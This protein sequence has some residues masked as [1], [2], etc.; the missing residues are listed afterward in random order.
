[1]RNLILSVLFLNLFVGEIIPLYGAEKVQDTPAIN[2][3]TEA[4]GLPSYAVYKIFK[5]SKGLMWFGTFNGICR[6]DG[7]A[8]TYFDIDCP[9]PL[10]SVTDIVETAG[11]DI[12]FGTRNGLYIVN[13]DEQKCQR[14]CPQIGFVNSLLKT[15]DC[16]Y[17]GSQNGL[18][19][20][21]EGEARSIKI[22]D[23]VISK[24][25]NVNDVISDG[26][27]GTWLCCDNRL[28]HLNQDGNIQEKYEIDNSLLIGTI[29][30]L[31]LLNG[32]VYIATQNS[33]LLVF[34]P[35][36][37]RTEQYIKLGCP[38]ISDIETDGKNLLYVSTDGN[39]AYVIDTQSDTITKSFRTDTPDFPLPDN[40]IYTYWH[41]PALN[42]DWFGFAQYGVCYRYNRQP[43]FKTYGYKDFNS[44]DLSTR[45][46]F[47]HDNEKAIGTRNGLWFI[48]ESRDIVHYFPPEETGGGIITD[49]QY[50]NGYFVIATFEKGLS[51]LNPKTLELKHLN[52]N[53]QLASANFSRIEP[54]Q[55]SL[56][57]ACSNIGLF[58]LDRNF[59]IVRHFHSRNSELPDSYICDFLIDLTGKG[60]IGT[61]NCLAIYDPQTQTIQSRDFPKEFFNNE[62]NLTFN[63]CRNGDILTVSETSAYRSKSD[64]SHYTTLDLYERTKAGNIF[65][66][67]ENRQGK[68]WIGTDKGLFL[69]EKDLKT[70]KQFNENDGL[71]SLKFNRNEFLETPDGTFWFASSKGLVYLRSKDMRKL[72]QKRKEKVIINQLTVDGLPVG[73]TASTVLTDRQSIKVGWNFRS[74]T[75]AV[76]PL[77]PDYSYPHGRYYEWD[78]DGSGYQSCVDGELI[79][80]KELSPGRHTLKIRLAGHEETA[81]TFRIAVWPSV[82][83]YLE[84]L[85][86]VMTTLSIYY[87]K[88]LRNKRARLKAALRRKHSLD[89]EIA[90]ARGMQQ[91]QMEQ[92]NQ[93]TEA[94]L[95]KAQSIQDK[96]KQHQN[97]YKA[98]YKKI[99][100]CMEEDKLYVNPDLRLTDLAAKIGCTP[101]KLSQMFN[102]YLHQNFFDFINAYRVE[103]FKRKAVSEKYSQYTIAAIS[104]TCG[105]KRSTFFATFKKFE[106]C[107]PTDWLNQHR[108]SKKQGAGRD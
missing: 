15:G 3:I 5:D 74:Q 54:L 30:R 4:N 63:L 25:N 73:P 34:T 20:Y 89:M 82:P 88:R 95:A 87:L 56:L 58:I 59:N 8:F 55:D 39:G 6:F 13:P 62:A 79:L 22:S 69:F 38:A 7:Q 46:F 27:G 19:K 67:T 44:R 60:W 53:K 107:T 21:E 33:G 45:S 57:F 9:K 47:I 91:Q 96:T 26:Q 77:I 102:H 72:E 97:E 61:I 17:V 16:I 41:D 106:Q 10:N 23:N 92:E 93:R 42:I 29:N 94:E 81:S 12:V 2:H 48:S 103:E 66:I 49:I 90:M 98:L 100:V 68:Y 28:M 35:K 71:P 32:K 24:G 108:T 78:L 1:M 80:L 36:D 70:Y 18:W 50:F 104:E 37:R 105:F 99:Q 85:L 86:V 101:T 11:R 83:F 31:C 76:R 51:I 43:L 75:L 40:G 52:H 84:I 64:L 65:F 14:I